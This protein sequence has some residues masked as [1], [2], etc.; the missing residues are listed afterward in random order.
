MAPDESQPAG[1]IPGRALRGNRLAGRVALVTGA[2]GSHD[3]VLGCGAATAML[4]AAQGAIVGLLDVS[5]DRLAVTA[6]AI[7]A[8][9]GAAVPLAA[10]ITDEPAVRAAL[11]KLASE[12]GRLDVVVNNAAITGGVER[13]LTTP[14]ESWERTLKVNL[15]GAMLVSRSA[16]PY[17]VRSGGGSIVNVSSVAANRGVGV[18]AYAA[19]KG[20]LQSL[21]ADLAFSWGQDGIRVNCIAPGHIFATLSGRMTDEARQTRRDATMLGTEGG[22]WDVA[23]AALFLA[24]EES[25]WITAA[26]LPVDGGATATTAVAIGRRG[27][28]LGTAS[29]LT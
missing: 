12:A 7:E 28:I 21:T 18:G 8:A 13:I 9:G 2:G 5:A 4:F 6:E 10:D 16:H 27:T 11:D 24:S 3:T 23:W 17:L 15:T 14:L 26:V 29:A 22:A 19:S 1:D 25:R 20:A